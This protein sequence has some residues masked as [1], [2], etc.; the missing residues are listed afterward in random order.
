MSV[1]AFR[2]G[3]SATGA[4]IVNDG[5]S[6]TSA[7]APISLSST[8]TIPAYDLTLEQLES[9]AP[10]PSHHT[11]MSLSMNEAELQSQLAANLSIKNRGHQHQ[12]TMIGLSAAV[13]PTLDAKVDDKRKST[14]TA[15]T[16][17][18]SA[19]SQQKKDKAAMSYAA[20]R[21]I[22]NGSFGV[23]YQATIVETNETVAIKKVLQDRR[24][25]NRE[26]QIMSQL[27]H[28]DV[29]QLKHCFYSKGEKPDE[30]YL[31]LVM[32]FI[33]E[34]VHR[35]LRNHTKANKLLPISYAR[36]YMWQICRSVAYIHSK[37][38]AHRDIKPQNLLLN[39]KSHEVKLCDFGSAK[40]LVAGE[41]NVSYIC[42]RYYR[43]PE[44]VFEAVEYTCSIDIWSVGCVMAEML[45]GNPIFPGE[46]GVDQLIEI[47]KVLGTPTKEEIFAMNP[48]HTSFKFPQIK[49]HPWAKVFRNR[50]PAD[51]IDF[52]SKLLR[53]DPKSRIDPLDALAHP[54]FNELRE[55]G[56]KLPNGKDLPPIFEFTSDE[57]RVM[58]ERNTLS[59][60]VPPHIL[61]NLRVPS[62]SSTSS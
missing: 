3:A 55:P 62:S 50:A 19:T 14:T 54:F 39:P 23:V 6:S 16:T 25:K 8:G 13:A 58:T 57:I 43:A 40:R 29:V 52:I 9:S 4:A 18:S 32:E 5:T 61:A 36:V 27:S 12:P 2:T 59:S 7:S 21:V 20:E 45:L 42:S 30:V 1:V 41:P 47:I 17:S 44:L 56:V 37:G 46:T 49:P 53:Y 24:F 26:L 31:N 10:P 38:I 28:P 60:I 33:P 11:S 35:T 34:T 22:G 48:N 51:A 15:A